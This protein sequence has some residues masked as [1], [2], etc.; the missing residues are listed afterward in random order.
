MKYYYVYIDTGVHMDQYSPQ[1]FFAL[2]T[3]SCF[4]F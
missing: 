4:V 3:I 1:N 2:A